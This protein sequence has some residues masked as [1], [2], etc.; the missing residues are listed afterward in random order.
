M[1]P[2]TIFDLLGVKMIHVVDGQR[3]NRTKKDGMRS[4]RNLSSK[5]SEVPFI[6][7]LAVEIYPEMR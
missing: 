6:S 4:L 2:E 3:T 1:P 7:M 5:N